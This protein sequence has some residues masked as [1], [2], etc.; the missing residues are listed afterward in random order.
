MHSAD[1]PVHRAVAFL[2]HDQKLTPDEE[3]HLVRC[4]ECR[5]LMVEAASNELD[6]TANDLNGGSNSA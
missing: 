2:L 1:T 3:E 5:R 4:D 6:L